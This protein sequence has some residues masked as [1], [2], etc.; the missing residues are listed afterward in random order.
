MQTLTGQITD[1]AG[2]QKEWRGYNVSVSFAQ[3]VDAADNTKIPLPSELVGDVASTGTFS[4]DLPDRASLDPATP[5]VVR[6]LAPAGEQLGVQQFTVQALADLVR[7]GTG[8]EFKVTPQAAFEVAPSKD[9]FLG[10]RPRLTGRVLDVTGERLIANRQ[11]LIFGI[12]RGS[13]VPPSEA[14][15]V[16]VSRTD[17][18]GYFTADY[19]REKDLLGE[20]GKPSEFDRAWGV[21]A[22]ARNPSGGNELPLPL[23]DHDP[24]RGLIPLD[25]LLVVDVSDDALAG[26]TTATQD[27]ACDS[28]VPR[29]PDVRDLTNS[30]STYSMDL[31]GGRCVNLT[32]PNR[33]L[34]EFSFYTVV[35]TTDPQIQGLGDPGTIVTVPPGIIKAIS[36]VAA[37]A[38]RP[39]A[40]MEMA[41]ART[42][43]T[44]A[45]P[46]T[47]LLAAGIDP[48][49]LAGSLASGPAAPE[50]PLAHAEALTAK[51]NQLAVLRSFYRREPGRG[52]LTATNSIDWDSDE[53]HFY[54][55][56]T[57]AN[58]HLLHFKQVWR[59]DGY[60]L[61]DLLYSLPLAPG[62]KKQIAVVDW[63]RR[64]VAQRSESLSESE[65]L[66]NLLT[67]DRDISEIV[68]TTLSE[69]M[70]GD[71]QS[72]TAGTGS[73]SGA[74]GSGSYG[75]YNLGAVA[76]SAIGAGF[77]S[78]DANQDASRGLT[79]NALQKIRDT[80]L[81]SASAVRNQR[82]TV[83]QTVSQGERVSV[84]TEVIANHNHCHAMTVEYFEVLRHF[85]VSQ[86]LADVQEAL[87]VPLLM[88][89]FDNR[90]ALRWRD[91]L[92]AYL[93]RPELGPGFDAIERIV[94]NYQDA[95]YPTGTY[96]EE[97]VLSV[98]GR[99]AIEV[100]LPNPGDPGAIAGFL[101][102]VSNFFFGSDPT[103]APG[104]PSLQIDA[105]DAAGNPWRIPME[106]TM[107]SE[108]ADRTPLYV[109]MEQA[110]AW[111]GAPLREQ[112]DRVHFTWNLSGSGFPDGT[113]VLIRSG[114]LRYRTAHLRNHLLFDDPSIDAGLT[115]TEAW[116]DCPLDDQE[117]RNLRHEDAVLARKL[118]AHLNEHIEYYHKAIWWS[119]DPDRRF[120]L[121]DGYIAPNSNGRSVASVVENRLI[122]FVGNSMVLPVG[123]GIHLDPSYKL[124]P[125]HPVDLLNRYAPLTPIPPMRISIPTR[126]VFAEAVLGECNS[127]EPKEE[128]R[129]WRWDEA[130]T[131]DEPTPIQSPSTDSRATPDPNLTAKD[132]PTPMIQIQ[133][134]PAEPDPTGL[135]AAL[136][137]IG[138]PNLFANITGLDQ[139]QK[140]SLAAMQSALDAAKHFGDQAAALVQQQGMQK[141]GID[142]SLQS[143]SQ[144]KKQNLIDDKQANDLSVSALKGLVGDKLG[145]DKK[146]TP[147][148]GLVPSVKD[149]V[150]KGAVKNL[151]ATTSAGD[152]VE[153]DFGQPD[154]ILA[155]STGT[156]PGK[157][158]ATTPTAPSVVAGL[159]LGFDLYQGNS[160]KGS[161][162][163]LGVS[164][165][166]DLLR[167]GRSFVIAKLG[168]TPGATNF[169]ADARFSTYYQRIR[170][171]GLIRG[172]YYF[173]DNVDVDTQIDRV[174]RGVVRLEPGDIAPALDIEDE[175]RNGV[176]PLDSNY[177][178]RTSAQGKTNLK[179]AIRKWLDTVETQLGKTPIV[180]TGA[181]WRDDLRWTDF[182]DHVLWTPHRNRMAPSQKVLGCWDDFAIWQ[183][184]EDGGWG[185]GKNTGY[186]EAGIN[187]GGID[188]NA[189]N[190][191]LYGLQG[192][193][194]MGRVGVALSM[195]IPFVADSELDDHLHFLASSGSLWSD[196]DL[197]GGGALPA[198]GRDPVLV[199]ADGGLALYFRTDDT[200]LEAA[201]NAA[202]GWAWDV[203]DLGAL[204]QVR[205]VD[206]PRA[207]VD[208]SKRY[209]V[210]WGDD[211]DWHLLTYDSGWTS[212]A[213][214]RAAGQGDSTGQPTVYVDG[215][216][217]H[218]VGRVDTDGH[219]IE[220]AGANNAWTGSDLTAAVRANTPGLPA[221]TY[222]PT[223]ARTTAG[224]FIAFRG[225]GGHIWLIDHAANTA[226]DLSATANAVLA[227][228]HP[229][230]FGLGNTVHVVYRGVDGAIYDLSGS[231]AAWQVQRVCDDPAASDP[232]ATA[233]NQVGVMSVRGADGMV[234][235]A[236]FD[237][238]A[239][240][241]QATVRPTP[242]PSPRMPPDE[243]SDGT[244][245]V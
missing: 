9:P 101:D 41:P 155:S 120:M 51:R 174:V 115:Q 12:P 16:A 167:K 217:A 136:K 191:N 68:D 7:S 113:R 231:G 173:F 8:V 172:S 159:A 53:P 211:N 45:R 26:A 144:A 78:A 124:D 219:L 60:S 170:D 46:R 19:P 220:V 6:V 65:G 105:V 1:A 134:A 114:T 189:F 200:L 112:I 104:G 178:Y 204:T 17:P 225:V 35:R 183:Y 73:G 49:I 21:V 149:Q 82:S 50:D 57:I 147:V 240:A 61:G 207:V 137:V 222:S 88:S 75:G 52:P 158:S 140:N 83:I 180:Y 74:A 208:G 132:F 118:L 38:T 203:T 128:T 33:A 214:L 201:A 94:T 238:A 129:F 236:R 215:G 165:F 30:P 181:S 86:E 131:G 54:E 226:V 221:A 56:T 153:A 163:P 77:S 164:D 27:C 244:I 109:R 111:L 103:V 14:T 79:A 5:I 229:T 227:A 197:S 198:T 146:T 160:L 119:M 162:Q 235:F 224:L 28:G 152:T 121:L 64:E 122:G 223:V 84:T 218:V 245:V 107:V 24:W 93:R 18:Q 161:S 243:L 55:A 90:K 242:P 205:A 182:T 4:L 213:L 232:V 185:P 72:L 133:N 66:Q 210:Y 62:Q 139:T 3:L 96:A 36:S 202:S 196:N 138:T 98:E 166:R 76:G 169:F 206:E 42:S 44:L 194:D 97:P 29:A 59:A 48:R 37:V 241:C 39:A 25:V 141:G 193:A 154:L 150:D 156:I 176:F 100:R 31:G 148:D 216:N 70:H 190:G 87:Y 157:A 116:V 108:P 142:K 92:F 67:R 135:A 184:G 145:A 22:G 212:V 199:E 234:Y 187:I 209:V 32:T 89:P 43:R 127:C 123:P 151:K 13:S 233:N 99:L 186:T 15:P 69:H 237:G 2:A 95:D 177:H 81:Q 175:N 230:S 20:P 106:F 10:T 34:E 130:P 143:I 58:G 239:W 80:T 40:V 47:G 110:G 171:A 228:G 168:G 85:Q 192:L 125:E 188:F 11:V 179:N 117:Q 63:E 195:G 126:G 102:S 23:E 91:I 71:S